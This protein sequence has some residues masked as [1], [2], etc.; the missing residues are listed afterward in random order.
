MRLVGLWGRYPSGSNGMWSSR[1]NLQM[2]NKPHA[3]SF[4][5]KT[6]ARGLI[7]LRE[8]DKILLYI[9]LLTLY[10]MSCQTVAQLC[11]RAPIVAMKGEI[12]VNQAY[13][14]IS[15]VSIPFP[16]FSL[17]LGCLLSPVFNPFNDHVTKN[18]DDYKTLSQHKIWPM[19]FVCGSIW[20]KQVR[21]IYW[22]G[23]LGFA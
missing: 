17:A 9:H 8:R 11:A 1:L 21:P 14:H 18:L 5:Y 16:C 7:E 6:M 15:T 3:T 13:I 12:M 23:S 10:F 20:T 4:R 19:Y 22:S 2:S